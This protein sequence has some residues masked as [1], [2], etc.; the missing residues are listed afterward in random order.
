M[1][2]E[3]GERTNLDPEPRSSEPS[4]RHFRID[5]D[6]PSEREPFWAIALIVT[7]EREKNVLARAPCGS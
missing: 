4:N 3:N 7:I 6:L 5:V 1:T 2:I